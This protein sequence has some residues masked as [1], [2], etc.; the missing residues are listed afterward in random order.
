MAS[1][2]CAV[3]A[4]QRGTCRETC[5][6]HH[7]LLL[8]FSPHSA[9][10]MEV[11]AIEECTIMQSQ[12]IFYHSVS[13]E[14]QLKLLSRCGAVQ[15]CPMAIRMPGSKPPCIQRC[16]CISTFIWPLLHQDQACWQVHVFCPCSLASWPTYTHVYSLTPRAI[17]G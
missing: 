1:M 3:V 14:E 16:S 4:P 12:L 7:L 13:S 17:Y 11:Q 9:N 15:L 10:R 2:T 5:S 8:L 6:L